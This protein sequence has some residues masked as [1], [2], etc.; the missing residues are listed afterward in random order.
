M[1][2][3][4][5][6]TGTFAD[7]NASRNDFKAGLIASFITAHS[8]WPEAEVVLEEDK[9]DRVTAMPILKDAGTVAYAHVVYIPEVSPVP[10]L[11]KAFVKEQLFS[12]YGQQW[13]ANNYGK[14]PTLQRNYAGLT[15]PEYQ[16]ILAAAAVGVHEPNYKEQ[17]KLN[18]VL[19]VELEKCITGAQTPK[20]TLA[21]LRDAASK[22][23]LSLV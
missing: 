1:A 7:H 4:Y 15:A 21:N 3:G 23:D 13:S 20:D 16:D 22:L 9:V 19:Q 12:L 8:R 17:A 5:T 14:L 11:A 6:P 18:D 2:A 10:D